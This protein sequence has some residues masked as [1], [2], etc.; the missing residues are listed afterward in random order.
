MILRN[1]ILLNEMNTENGL[2]V[3]FFSVSM[4]TNTAYDV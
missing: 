2:R 4:F 3:T 1:H